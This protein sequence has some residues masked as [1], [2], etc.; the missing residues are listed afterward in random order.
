VAASGLPVMAIQCLPCKGGFWVVTGNVL[1]DWECDMIKMLNRQTDRIILFITVRFKL[2]TCL[3]LLPLSQFRNLLR[4][5]REK[6]IISPGRKK[7][8]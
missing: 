1:N 4:E 7:N 6:N 8:R 5:K 2:E 3:A